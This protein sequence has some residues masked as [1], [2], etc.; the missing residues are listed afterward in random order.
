MAFNYNK[1]ESFYVTFDD[2][3]KGF[4]GSAPMSSGAL[5]MNLYH[6]GGNNPLVWEGH[7]TCNSHNQNWFNTYAFPDPKLHEATACIRPG[8]CDF[9][10]GGVVVESSL[11]GSLALTAACPGEAISGSLRLSAPA[12]GQWE[13]Y[14]FSAA[15]A[16]ASGQSAAVPAALLSLSPAPAGNFNAGNHSFSLSL[17][18]LA[19][20]ALNNPDSL[21]ISIL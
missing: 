19:L 9:I 13:D 18:P 16:S 8:V 6:S 12:P 15:L 5:N 17:S 1:P 20:N 10:R 4:E 2:G 14:E 11:S 3:G 21:V 7:A